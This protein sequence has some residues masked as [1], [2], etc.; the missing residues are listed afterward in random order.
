MNAPLLS[1]QNES[2]F[3]RINCKEYNEIRS[4]SKTC[5]FKINHLLSKV[6][7]ERESLLQENSHL[8]SLLVQEAGYRRIYKFN[9]GFAAQISNDNSEFEQIH[10]KILLLHKE[11][12]LTQLDEERQKNYK[13]E[14]QLINQNQE[15]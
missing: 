11:L 1:N 2:E 6:L 5:D 8:L 12:M 10:A 14:L 7:K 3:C 9:P 15:I 4:Y 13:Q